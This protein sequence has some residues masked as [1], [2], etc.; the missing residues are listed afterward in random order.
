MYRGCPLAR[1]LRNS[2]NYHS[3]NIL[4]LLKKRN[5]FASAMRLVATLS[6]MQPMQGR[7]NKIGNDTG[8]IRVI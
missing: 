4:K 2:V 5:L 1:L 7:Y 6:R 8:I 3:K